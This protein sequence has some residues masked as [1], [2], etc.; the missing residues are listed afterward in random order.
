[1][2]YKCCSLHFTGI[3]STST[4]GVKVLEDDDLPMI[5]FFALTKNCLTLDMVIGITLRKLHSSK[6]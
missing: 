1:M 3:S 2:D 4:G 6:T 5:T